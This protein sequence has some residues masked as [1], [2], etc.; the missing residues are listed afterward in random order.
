MRTGHRAP[1]ADS[2]LHDSAE[3]HEVLHV[4][5]RGDRD[6]HGHILDLARRKDPLCSERGHRHVSLRHEA[7][8]ML[9]GGMDCIQIDS[10]LRASGAQRITAPAILH[11]DLLPGGWVTCGDA[12]M[13]VGGENERRETNNNK[14]SERRITSPEA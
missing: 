2:A 14:G 13:S 8:D 7:D 10:T 5:S 6:E 11:E 9:H 1:S 4:R 12:W 3:R